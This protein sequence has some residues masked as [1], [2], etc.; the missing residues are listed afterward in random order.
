[1]V[2]LLAYA[3]AVWSL[4]FVYRRRWPAFVAV[5]LALPPVA[6]AVHLDVLFV[7]HFFGENVDWLYAL[8]GAFAALVVGV[9]LFIAVQPRAAP[10]YACR[11]CH[12]DLRGN[13]IGVCPECGADLTIEPHKRRPAGRDD[14]P[15]Q[16][17]DSALGSQLASSRRLRSQ[18]S[19][20][21]RA[22]TINAPPSA[23]APS[24]SQPTPVRSSA[25]AADNASSAG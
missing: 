24:Q 22:V 23:E 6:G 25:R 20:T 5:A 12:Y 18:R 9:G 8:A 7:E 13:A 1:M 14:S 2:F 10:A 11:F 15:N 3:F 19:A 17:P 4:A 16:P 21:L